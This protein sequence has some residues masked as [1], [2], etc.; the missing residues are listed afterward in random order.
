MALSR[1]ISSLASYDNPFGG[2]VDGAGVGN[3][4]VFE[5]LV[6]EGVANGVI[7]GAML[8]TCVRLTPGSSSSSKCIGF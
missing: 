5:E 3:D 2:P 4:R 8:G 1:S 7:D 6:G